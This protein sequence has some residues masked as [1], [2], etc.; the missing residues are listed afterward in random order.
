VIKGKLAFVTIMRGC[1]NF[2]TFCVVPYTRGRERSRPVSS[3]IT[4]I[5]HL[6]EKGIQEVTLLGQNVNSYIHEDSDFTDLIRVILKETQIQRL[7]FT[8]PHPMDFPEKLLN[9]MAEEKR[10]CSHIHLPLQSGNTEV[11]KRMKRGY[12]RE[13]FLQ[14]VMTIRENIP[15]VGLT[16]DIITGFSG[17]TDDEF[18]DTLSLVRE[19]QFDMAYMFKYSEREKTVASRSYPDDVPEEVKLERLNTLIQLQNQISKDVNASEVGN[20]HE[21]MI[22]GLS[23]RSKEHSSGRTCS[24][25]VVIIPGIYEPGSF[26]SALIG[27]STSATLFGK[28]Q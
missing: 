17:E 5:H 9:L 1:N 16:T 24:N 19:V 6:A 25:K 8:S 21:I 4:E 3:I 7:R 10:F 26:V 23:R 27:D 12:S 15:G 20:L 22:E 18:N 11:L 14:L 28:V 2:C 13:D